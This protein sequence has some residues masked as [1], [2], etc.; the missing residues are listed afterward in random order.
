M[1]L[2]IF[3]P[4]ELSVIAIYS[5]WPS[6][7]IDV[8]NAYESTMATTAVDTMTAI[9]SSTLTQRSS[10]SNGQAQSARTPVDSANG[11]AIDV[12]E[13][14]RRLRIK[15][16]YRHVAAVHSRPQTTCLSHDAAEIPSFLGF[17]NLMV[18]VLGKLI[19]LREKLKRT[20]LTVGV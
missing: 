2:S 15:K 18:I 16:K 8:N 12:P 10:H 17:R 1:L 19:Q 4:R 6:D 7:D 14:S 13:V 20:C 3:S 9:D 11:K 5:P